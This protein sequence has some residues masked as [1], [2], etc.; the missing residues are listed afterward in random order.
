MSYDGDFFAHVD[1]DR[2]VLDP[3]AKPS[4]LGERLD[5]R[6]LLRIANNVTLPSRLHYRGRSKC[7]GSPANASNEKREPWAT[8]RDHP[9]DLA[10]FKTR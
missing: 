2:V 9:T 6:S 7:F 5:C 8:S 4:R 10:F 3:A 1:N